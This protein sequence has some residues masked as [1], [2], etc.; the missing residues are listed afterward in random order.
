[1]NTEK[2]REYCLN[3]PT[4]PC[5]SNGCPLHNDIPAFIHAKSYQQAYDILCKTTVLPAVCGRICPHFKQCRG[6][7]IR[8]FKGEAVDIG[9]IETEIGDWSIGLLNNGTNFEE[10]EIPK[11]ID[12]RLV[13]KRVAVIGGGPA[14]LTC[15]AFL[16]MSGVK[17]TIFEKHEKLGGILNHGIPDFRLDEVVVDRTIDKI[18]N[19]GIEVKCGIELGKDYQLNDL[20]DRFDAVFISVGANES[21]CSLKGENV[22]SGNKIL[23]YKD[24]PDL[25]NKN[26]II[27]GGGNVAIDAARTIAKKSAN[28]KVVYRRSKEQMPAEEKEIEEAFNEGIEF[29][30]QTNIISVNFKNKTIECTKN[31]LVKKE[32]EDRLYPVEIPNS[33]YCMDADYIIL[34][35]GSKPDERITKYFLKNE[36]GYISVDNN[37]KTSI[38]KVFAGGNIIGTTSTVAWASFDGREAAKSIINELLL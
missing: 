25:K 16:A 32:E 33:N 13:N 21:I 11:N 26:V 5:S 18:L 36:K 9:R 6:S 24:F 23:E 1:M 17:V 34:A 22:L 15:S 4:K 29:V 30:F 27:N 31:D 3:C 20:L 14:G 7:C 12:E 19:L 8:S 35:T 38:N 37:Y 28:V 2:L 10:I